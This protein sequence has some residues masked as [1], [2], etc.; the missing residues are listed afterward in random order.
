MPTTEKEH[1]FHN[2]LPG[3]PGSNEAFTPQQVLAAIKTIKALA[4]TNLRSNCSFFLMQSCKL[5][6]QWGCRWLFTRM[7]RLMQY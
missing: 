2:A 5:A 6:K 1:L 4:L 7:I 3:L